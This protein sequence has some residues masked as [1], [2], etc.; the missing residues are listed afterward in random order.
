MSRKLTGG[1][2][3]FKVRSKN[4]LAITVPYT[5]QEGDIITIEREYADGHKEERQLFQQ[6]T[7]YQPTHSPWKDGGNKQ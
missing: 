4:G 1:R 5:V 7:G 2:V 6:S 3:T